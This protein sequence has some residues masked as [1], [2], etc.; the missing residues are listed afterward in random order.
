MVFG[1][2]SMSEKALFFLLCTIC[3]RVFSSCCNPAVLSR[4]Y[5]LRWLKIINMTHFPLLF[6]LSSL[7]PH[8][9]VILCFLTANKIS[10]SS[11]ATPFISQL[12]PPSNCGAL[13]SS[14]PFHLS[15]RVSTPLLNKVS[16]GVIGPKFALTKSLS[17][18]AAPFFGW[19]CLYLHAR[20]CICLRRIYGGP[21]CGSTSL[22]GRPTS[23]PPFRHPHT[24]VHTHIFYTYPNVLDGLMLL[25]ILAPLPPCLPRITPSA[26]AS[27]QP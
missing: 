8:G 19:F 10:P 5:S 1:Y 17:A 14:S 26:T 20:V 16:V 12:S 3:S 2:S 4:I 9:K 18:Q 11:S 22:C 15:R 6:C 7:A 23:Q 24:Y 27:F 25:E 21:V 13:I